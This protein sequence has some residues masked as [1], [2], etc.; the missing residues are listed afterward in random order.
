MFE[1]E[2]IPFENVVVDAGEV[3]VAQNQGGERIKPVKG[4][5]MNRPNLVVRKVEQGQLIEVGQG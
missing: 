5:V 3:I 4:V 1:L 2:R